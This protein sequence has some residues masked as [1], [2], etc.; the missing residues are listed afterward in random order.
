MLRGIEIIGKNV[1]IYILMKRPSILPH[2]NA[3]RNHR[4]F[5]SQDG[6]NDNN[7][8]Y[9]RKKWT[10]RDEKILDCKFEFNKVEIADKSPWFDNLNPREKEITSSFLSFSLQVPG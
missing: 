9:E 3:G 5:S 8:K 4:G 2:I 7:L 1:L 10:Q 6:M